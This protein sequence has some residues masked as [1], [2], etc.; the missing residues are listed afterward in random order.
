MKSKRSKATD[1]SMSTKRK[2]WERDNECCIICGSH[3][4]MPNAH[5]LSRA[6]GG[7]GIE[8]NV[9][10]LCQQCHFNY[11]NGKDKRVSE[12]IKSKIEDYLSSK[13]DNW[14]IEDLKYKK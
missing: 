2:V 10:T 9:I 3:Y 1:I 6:K 5:F 13:Y 8:Q 14:N 11:D 12:E 4:A 7:L